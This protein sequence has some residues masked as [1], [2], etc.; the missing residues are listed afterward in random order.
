MEMTQYLRENS[1]MS[2]ALAFAIDTLGVTLQYNTVEMMGL[3][4][5]KV[6]H[7]YTILLKIYNSRVKLYTG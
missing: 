7:N 2:L 1:Q 6:R 5:A 4:L 3:K